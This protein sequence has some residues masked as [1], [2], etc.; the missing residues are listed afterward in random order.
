MEDKRNNAGLYVLIGLAINRGGCS[1]SGETNMT[2][3]RY[4]HPVNGHVETIGPHVRDAYFCAGPFFFLYRG[5]VAH[6][7]MQAVACIFTFGLAHLLYL[8]FIRHIL[9]THLLQ[10]ATLASRTTRHRQTPPVAPAPAPL[11]PSRQTSFRRPAAVTEQH[12]WSAQDYVKVA[13]VALASFVI[14]FVVVVAGSKPQQQTMVK[15]PAVQKGA[16][17]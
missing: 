2:T 6:A 17:R 3:E 8:P 1:G 7:A 11:A 5:M 9:R 13:A 16:V 14:V 4:R 15:S 10:Q 12:A